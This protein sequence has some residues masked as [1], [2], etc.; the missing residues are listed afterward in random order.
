MSNIYA[1]SDCF[2]PRV[3]RNLGD[4]YGNYETNNIKGAL[5]KLINSIQQ[6]KI[7]GNSCMK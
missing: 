7:N 3:K 1:D 4:P 5:C 2:K 6:I